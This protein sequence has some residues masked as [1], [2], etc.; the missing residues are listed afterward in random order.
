MAEQGHEKGQRWMLVAVVL[1]AFGLRLYRLGAGSLWYDE[2][3]SVHLAGQSLREL[4]AHTAGDIHPPGYYL[5]LHVW[6]RL[7]GHSQFSAAFLSLAFGLLLVALTYAL[8]AHLFGTR[9]GSLAAFLVAISPYN[10]WY[11]QEVRMYTL[12]A[13]LGMGLL[14]AMIPLWT[15]QPRT[16]PPWTRLGAYTLCGVLGLWV[17]YYFAFLLLAINLMVSV[18]WLAGRRRKGVGWG[19]LGRW[20]LAQGAVLLLYAPWIPVAWRQATDPP[21]PPWRGFS[22]LGNL[23]LE[24]WSA[25]SLGQSVEAEQVWPVLVL[26][27]ILF[28]L[29][30]VLKTLEARGRWLLAGYVFLPVWLI[31]LA[32]FA[33]PL[34]HVRYAFTYSTPFYVILAAGLDSLRRRWRPALWLSLVVVVLFS[35]TS[36]YAY[37]TDPRYAAD[38]HRAATR[39]LA[40][41]WRP[42]DATLVNAGYVYTALV[43]YWHDEPTAWWG[44]LVADSGAG[45]GETAG[46]GPVMV[47]TGTVDGRPSLGWGNPDS[48]FYAMSQA[49]TAE[50]LAR[51]FA[52]FD[53]VWVYRCYDTVTDPDGFIRRWLGEHG[54]LFEDRVFSGQSQLR[55]QGFLTGRDPLAGAGRPLHTALSDGSLRLLASSDWPP[56]VEVGGALDLALVW[57]VD[58]PPGDDAILFAGLFDAKGRRW[59]QM[60]STRWAPSTP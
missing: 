24:T 19:W 30:L 26:V 42:G 12:A 21:V 9:V 20:T 3:V 49:E 32:S 4:V 52:E 48:D 40:A 29:G 5:L 45:F 43:T 7:A 56:A 58:S 14:A 16:S 35:G 31:Y 25:L 33:T 37:H 60:T 1:L 17:L 11:S 36:I 44:R 41:R 51:L 46:Q 15:A 18:W 23:L 55:V 8:A 59:A 53:R 28:G 34:Y 27:A 6:T 13:A 57:H 50:S 2:T 22:G 10:L 54:V 39:F 38:D 47:Q